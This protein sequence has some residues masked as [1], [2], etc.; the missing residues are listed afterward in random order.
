M[1]SNK[2]RYEFKGCRSRAVSLCHRL[3]SGSPEKLHSGELH[4]K[5]ARS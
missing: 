1:K 2:K 4:W 3:F 5:D